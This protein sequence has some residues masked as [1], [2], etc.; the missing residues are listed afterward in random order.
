MDGALTPFQIE[1][2]R[3]FFRLPASAGYTVAGGAALIASELIDRPTED[4]DLFTHG[5]QTTIAP[6]REAF[7][8]ALDARGWEATSVQDGVT[9]CRLIVGN[10]TDDVVVDLAVDTPPATPPTMTVLGPTLA[11]LELAGRKLLALFGRAEARDFADVY[12]LAQR[13]GTDALLA[14]AEAEDPGFDRAILAQMIG[15]HQRFT[16]DEIPAPP[17][18]A[19][20]LRDFFTEWQRALSNSPA[21]STESAKGD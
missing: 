17:G 20:Q 21:P 4:L 9:F 14:Q 18:E 12:V 15:S 16:D 11:P 2:A 6:A 10:G 7:L 5:R 19:D 13:F 8:V 3:L 1:V